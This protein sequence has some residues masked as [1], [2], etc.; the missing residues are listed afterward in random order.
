MQST[1]GLPGFADDRRCQRVNPFHI[2]SFCKGLATCQTFLFCPEW[3]LPPINWSVAMAHAL[4]QLN[5]QD[6]N[7]AAVLRVE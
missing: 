3:D 5:T 1:F 6:G 7:N 4:S 2:N